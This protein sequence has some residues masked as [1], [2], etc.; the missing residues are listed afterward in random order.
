MLARPNPETSGVGG[1]WVRVCVGVRVSE[2]RAGCFWWTSNSQ[3]VNDYI[4]VMYLSEN[5]NLAQEQMSGPR[6]GLSLRCLKNS[7]N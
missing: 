7:G 4:T 2:V 5:Q 3:S 6:S 1:S